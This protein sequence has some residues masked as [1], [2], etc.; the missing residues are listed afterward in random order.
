MRDWEA[1]GDR[2]QRRQGREKTEEE[3]ERYRLNVS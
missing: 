1:G 2:G 3:K